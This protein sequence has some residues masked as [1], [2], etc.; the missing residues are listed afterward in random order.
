MAFLHAGWRVI[1][2]DA[3]Q[4]A[5]WTTRMRAIRNGFSRRLDCIQSP[6][7][8]VVFSSCAGDCAGVNASFSLPFCAQEAF[9]EVWQRLV[10]ALPSGGVFSGQFFGSNDT[11]ASAP[12]PTSPTWHVSREGEENFLQDFTIVDFKE[13]DEQ[14]GGP[15]GT[16]K[17]WHVYHIVAVK[18]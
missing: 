10:D 18:R 13:V 5:G 8:E 2:V 4:A 14:G 9:P 1:A 17:H 11:W 16:V 6:I 7:E 12:M 15:R 3:S